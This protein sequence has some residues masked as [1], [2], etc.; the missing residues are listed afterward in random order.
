M[1]NNENKVNEK[2]IDLINEKDEEIKNLEIAFKK[3][4]NMKKQYKN[5]IKILNEKMK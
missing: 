3:E 4:K 5:N 2:Y 1:L